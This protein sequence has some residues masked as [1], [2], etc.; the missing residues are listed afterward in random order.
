MNETPATSQWDTVAVLPEEALTGSTPHTPAVVEVPDS[1]WGAL[2]AWVAGPRLLRR[3]PDQIERHEVP[4]SH[5]AGGDVAR[6]TRQRNSVDQNDIDDGIDDYLTDAGVPPRPRGYRWFLQLP[7]GIDETQFWSQLNARLD[8][9]PSLP[10]YPADL[11]PALRTV[12]EQMY[13]DQPTSP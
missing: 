11:M 10:T 9:H 5:V 12:I 3:C 1:G 4:L 7:T 8:Q 13:T 2:V 6:V